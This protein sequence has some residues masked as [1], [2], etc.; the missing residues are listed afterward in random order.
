MFSLKT[1]IG[2]PFDTQNE[3]IVEQI[4]KRAGFNLPTLFLFFKNC[5]SYGKF[6]N[7]L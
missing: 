4:L 6:T 1:V 7:K 3:K 5:K 2:K